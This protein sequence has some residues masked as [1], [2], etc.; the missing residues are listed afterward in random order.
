M[1]AGVPQEFRNKTKRV[2]SYVCIFLEEK[3]WH[4]SRS[5]HLDGIHDPICNK[6]GNRTSTGLEF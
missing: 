2:S 3:F 4:Y 5:T 1:A 6:E